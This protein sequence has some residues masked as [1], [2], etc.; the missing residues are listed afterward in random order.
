MA[1]PVELVPFPVISERPGSGTISFG[2]NGVSGSREWSVP[3][4]LG[5]GTNYYVS[6]IQQLLGMTIAGPSGVPAITYPD[7]FSQ[8]F[9][10]LFCQECDV[11]GED[12]AGIDLWGRI[13]YRRAVV[14][15]K[16][17]PFD[18]GESFSLSA[19]A[20][21]IKEN[22]YTF[23]GPFLTLT[24]PPAYEEELPKYV[25]KRTEVKAF[26]ADPFDPKL[27][28]FPVDEEVLDDSIEPGT[29]SEAF[30][31]KYN[32]W[33]N[34]IRA[35]LASP[36]ITDDV[37]QGANACISVYLDGWPAYG[38][39]VFHLSF[40]FPQAYGSITKGEHVTSP[41]HIDAT[42]D[43]I[44]KA[45]IDADIP[46][47]AFTL[48]GVKL[49]D[50]AF[51]INFRGALKG[52]VIDAPEV[53]DEV[54]GVTAEGA[55]PVHVIVTINELAM[56][57]EIGGTVEQPITKIIPM[58]EYSLERRQVLAPA[59]WKFITL[60]GTINAFFWLG[61][62]PWTLMFSGMEG[63]RTVLPNGTRTWDLTF[64]F[65]FNPNTWNMIF[66]PKTGRWEVVAAT[67]MSRQTF[68]C[69][70]QAAPDQPQD[71]FE[72]EDEL[73]PWL[74]RPSDFSAILEYE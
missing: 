72:G 3:W 61:F 21:S 18:M 35:R 66:R 58:G 1:I 9:P 22:T 24:P 31:K 53:V 33:L 16:Y 45:I 17:M 41:I 46:E 2:K 25:T 68:W 32:E 15:A 50:G 36:G 38:T 70:N 52:V 39:G 11:K 10:W 29:P 34:V 55:K 59:F 30:L 51:G 57:G 56:K 43:D 47:S 13:Q 20:L 19:Q 67:G 74:Y 64:K 71:I 4:A 6:F 42:L 49:A 54:I 60:L 48:T 7:S 26:S 62:P 69:I 65:H 12:Q 73:H 44:K 37:F 40:D 28:I 5:D 23:L 8:D 63:K 14:A 27:L